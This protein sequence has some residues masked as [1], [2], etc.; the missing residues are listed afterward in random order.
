MEKVRIGVIGGSGLYQ[1]PEISDVREVDMDTPFGPPSGTIRIGSLSGK[2]VAF[3][4]RHGEGHTLA[5]HALP[6]R[7]NIYALKQLGA[8]FII[9]VNAVGSLQE[10]YAPGQ[11]VT[12]DQLIDYT[13]HTRARSFFERGLVVH[14]SVADPFGDYLRS[15]L[16]DA[17]ESSGAVVHR[18]GCFL[19][20]DG[21][22]FATRA[23]ARLFQR[24]GCH[25][26]GMTA[27]PEAFLA[28]EA[29]IEYAAL[30][31]V[32]DYDCWRTESEDTTSDIVIQQLA[33]NIGFVQAALVEAVGQL[34]ETLELPAH[35]ALDAALATGREHMDAAV[36]ER[37][38]PIVARV[39]GLDV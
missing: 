34:D 31:H 23:E 19:I 37:L 9:G 30:A 2:R 21:P 33:Q 11:L 3:L 32:T 5:P 12:P 1:L 29:E 13:I 22:R 14:V 10:E 20:E 15:L 25:I 28:R 36:V 16:A 26:I 6:Y 17:A 27:A 7:A 4:P 18:G 39:L 38:R 24:W 35:R 8:R